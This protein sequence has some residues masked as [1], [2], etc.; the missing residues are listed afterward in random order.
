L[1]ASFGWMRKI[2]KDGDVI[3]TTEV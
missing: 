1:P 2:I 3:T